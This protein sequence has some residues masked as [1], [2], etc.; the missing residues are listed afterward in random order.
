MREAAAIGIPA[1]VSDACAAR[2][3]IED[4]VTGLLFRS[5]DAEDLRRQIE[6]C[7]DDALVER[8]GRTAYARYWADPP[9][10]DAHADALEA[11]Y[12]HVLAREPTHV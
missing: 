12:A 5:G 2:E 9:T 10:V 1:I 4:G 7:R 11:L 6:R 8:M 3:A